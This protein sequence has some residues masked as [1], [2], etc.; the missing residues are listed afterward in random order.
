[1]TAV[2]YIRHIHDDFEI[3]KLL[4][5]EQSLN[6]LLKINRKLL[7]SKYDRE[8]AILTL[9]TRQSNFVVI[10][11]GTVSSKLLKTWTNRESKL[12]TPV[13]SIK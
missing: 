5:N 2:F 13:H 11:D 12:L 9:N 6:L 8:V 1:M 3:C 4:K 10:A 7:Y